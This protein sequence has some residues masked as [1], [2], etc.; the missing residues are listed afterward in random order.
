MVCTNCTPGTGPGLVKAG[1]V[2]IIAKL[3]TTLREVPL[4][5]ER[6]QRFHA[7][8]RL[9]HGVVSLPSG[10]CVHTICAYGYTNASREYLQRQRTRLSDLGGTP[11]VI[12]GG[13]L[14]TTIEAS[15][16]LNRAIAAQS[17][18]D[19]ALIQ[20]NLDGQAHKETFF[21]EGQQPWQSSGF[22]ARKFSRCEC[23]QGPVHQGRH[24]RARSSRP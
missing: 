8:G 22:L 23:V 24:R 1:G 5:D 4:K 10:E 14:N 20:S 18:H 7:A 17:L 19:L 2:A 9:L 15:A 3:G 13:D 21:H 11:P 6:A 16:F 12:V